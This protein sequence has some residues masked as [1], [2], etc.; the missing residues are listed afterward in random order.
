MEFDTKL[1]HGYKYVDPVTG[2]TSIPKYQAS[3]FQQLNFPNNQTYSYSR[4]GNPTVEYLENALASLE[5]AK[6]GVCLSSGIAA[7]SSVLLTLHTGDHI[8]LGN[9]VYGGT[10]QLVEELNERYEVNFTCVD[11]TNIDSWKKAINSRTKLLYIETPS[12]PLLSITD[13]REIVKLAKDKN[14]LTVADN[15]FMTPYYQ[16]PLSLGVDIVIQSCTKFLGGHSDIILGFVATNDSQ[17]YQLIQNNRKEFGF[18]PG[19]E[20]CWLCMRGIKTLAVRLEKSSKSAEKLATLLQNVDGVK[21]V[22]YPGLSTHD[23]HD[24]HLSQ[25]SNGG[26]VVSFELE[27]EGLTKQLLKNVTIPIVAVSL[28]GVESILSYPWSMSHAC[29]SEKERLAMGVTPNLV[30]LSVGVENVN[31]LFLDIKNSIG[32]K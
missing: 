24:T 14:I 31:D 20:E 17:L 22:Y 4:F 12:N 7:I 26:M 18:T 1:I 15:T 3:T 23:G 16:N 2:A 27:S 11:E 30:R 28:G 10:K 19:V 21:K 8:V 13:I 29:I 5:N 6:Y 32:G 25:S 9:N